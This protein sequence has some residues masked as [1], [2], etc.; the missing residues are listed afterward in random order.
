MNENHSLAIRV[1]S[2]LQWSHSTLLL[3]ASTALLSQLSG[4]SLPKRLAAVPHA[5]TTAAEVPGFQDVR[6]WIPESIDLMIEDAKQS[7][8]TQQ[9]SL[10]ASGS[11]GPLPELNYLAVSGGGDN[12]AFGAGLLVGWSE[13]GSRPEFGVVTGISTGALIAPFAFVGPEYDEE[14]KKAYTEISSKNIFEERGVLSVLFDDALAD[15]TPLWHMIE[16]CYDEDLLERIAQEHAKGRWLLVATTDLD[17]LRPV[18]WNITKIAASKKPGALELFRKILLASASIPGFFP[19]VMFDVEVEGQAHQ[20]MHVDGGAVSQ[21]FLVPSQFGAVAEERG[22]V[23][24][25]T[26]RTAYIIR[27]SRIDPDWASV[28]RGTLSI[29]G[30]AITSLIQTQGIGDLYQIYLIT[31]RHEVDFNLAY[32]GS[33]FNAVHKEQFDTEYMRQLFDYGYQLGRKGYPWRKGP[34]G[35]SD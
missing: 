7:L 24:E 3:A 8:R 2:R 9:E 6:Y 27:N 25:R 29:A 16:Q 19:P 35:F 20:E 14:L 28:E 5:K 10:S 4:C 21:V 26:G 11:N 30:R 18:I 12:G 15:T 32:V 33:D 23:P 22:L 1:T 34:P 13:E 31:Q 17:A